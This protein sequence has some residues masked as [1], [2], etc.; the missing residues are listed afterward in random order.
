M[1]EVFG[2]AYQLV[3]NGTIFDQAFVNVFWYVVLEGTGFEADDL[4]VAFKI[5]ILPSICSVQNVAVEYQQMV[6]NGVRDSHDVATIDIVESVGTITGDCLPPYAAWAYQ[7]SRSSTQMRNG[8]KRLPGVSESWQ[9]NGEAVEGTP[10]DTLQDV[11]ATMHTHLE[12]A[13]GTVAVMTVPRRQF[14]G[15][16]V[17]PVQYWEGADCNYV[18]ISTQNTRKFGR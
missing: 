18:R 3:L 4:G 2:P 9:S 15:V 5:G 12:L 1:A 16:V 7:I 17:D 6:I 11:G 14:H 8:Y 10:A 13:G